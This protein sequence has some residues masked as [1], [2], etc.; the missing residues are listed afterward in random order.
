MRRYYV[1]VIF[2]NDGVPRYVGAGNGLRMER[3]RCPSTW[4]Y[5]P[6]GLWLRALGRCPEA[7]RI[8][9]GLTFEEANAWERHLIEFIG[10][11][12]E[13]RGTLLNVQA[14]GMSGGGEFHHDLRPEKQPK[15]K[16]KPKPRTARGGVVVSQWV[17]PEKQQPSR[18]YV[19][20]SVRWDK[21]S[22]QER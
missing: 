18:D 22:R 5:N 9:T 11:R 15:P 12:C 3:W 8:I 4:G 10:R 2:D 13:G 21:A 14:G 19:P 20:W 6:V 1:Y 7:R 17:P 16:P